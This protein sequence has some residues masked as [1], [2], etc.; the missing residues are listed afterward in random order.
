VHTEQQ[1]Q[2]SAASSPSP[3]PPATAAPSPHIGPLSQLPDPAGG[4]GAAGAGDLSAGLPRLRLLDAG[5]GSRLR[6]ASALSEAELDLAASFRRPAASLDSSAL[7][8]PASSAG[9]GPGPVPRHMCRRRV[10]SGSVCGEE[11]GAEVARFGGALFLRDAEL[12]GAALPCVEGGGGGL[13]VRMCTHVCASVPRHPG[14][15]GP[16]AH[17]L[18]G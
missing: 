13:R 15:L 18:Q 10:R 6:R 16:G 3:S 14:R 11:D 1:R 7:G 9:G 5:S 2:T 8:G 12:E 4:D 17:W